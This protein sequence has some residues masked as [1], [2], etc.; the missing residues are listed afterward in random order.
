MIVEKTNI[1]G[2]I[3]LTPNVFADSRGY[4]LESYN[5]K[6]YA[7]IGINEVFVQDNESL[8]QKDVLRGLHFQAP[9]FAQAKLVRVIK[10]AVLDIAVDIREGSPTYGQYFSIVLSE[11]NK[12]QFYIPAG[13]AHGFKTIENN[14]IFSYKCTNFYNKESEGCISWDDQDIQI[15]W[16]IK[17]PILSD[18]DKLG[19]SLK[20]FISPF[21]Y[22]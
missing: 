22:I 10:G 8:S 20:K 3:I 18:K 19:I 21:K 7:N 17:N 16:N 1:E 11:E 2:L 15:E 14:T 12:K 4:F 6:S 5:Q 9:P 13:F